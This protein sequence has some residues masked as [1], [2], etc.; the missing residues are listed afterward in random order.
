MHHD[1]EGW[2]GR[3]SHEQAECKEES[4]AIV[5]TMYDKTNIK[6]ELFP[7]IHSIMPQLD[8]S[9]YCDTFGPPFSTS[10]ATSRFGFATFLP[11]KVWPTNGFGFS[12]LPAAGQATT[13]CHND[14]RAS[15]KRL[16][17]T[18]LSPSKAE[19]GKDEH[20]RWHGYQ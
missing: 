13:T 17:A 15:F 3:A 19:H 20:Q 10:S 1:E 16:K 4:F 9:T 14:K 11:K 7:I 18:C 12:L 5:F 6:C 8:H 2:S